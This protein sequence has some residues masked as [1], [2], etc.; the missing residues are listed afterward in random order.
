MCVKFVLESR[1]LHSNKWGCFATQNTGKSL[2]RACNHRDRILAIWQA[3]MRFADEL[4]EH[5]ICQGI[6]SPASWVRK[7]CDHDNF[8]DRHDVT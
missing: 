5:G 2:M 4:M 3:S 1:V 7:I 8:Y 6:S